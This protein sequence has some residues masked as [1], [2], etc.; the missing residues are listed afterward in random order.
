MWLDRLS[1]HSTQPSPSPSSTPV[2]ARSFSP[3]PNRRPYLTPGPQRP[4]LNP[5]SSSLSLL[6]PNS[7]SSSLPLA[8][9]APTASGLRVQI[10]SS[11][12]ADVQDPS[13]VLEDILRG[14]PKRALPDD[15]PEILVERPEEVVADIE[16]GDLSLQ[17]FAQGEVGYPKRPSHVHTRSTE[18]VEEYGKAKDKFE[19]LHRSVA[20]CDEVLKSVEMYLQ[21]FQSDLGAV[22]AEIQILQDRSS[23]LNT[24]LENRKIVEKILGPAVEDIS[25]SP[26]VV[27]KIAEGPVDEGFSKALQELE[28][29]SKAV[30]AKAKGGLNV[31]A[32]DDLK[33]LLEDLTNKAVERIRDYIVAQIKAL[34]SPSINA[35]IIQQQGFLKYKE[36]YAFLARHQKQLAEELCRAYINTMRWYYLHHFTRYHEA[37]QKMK[38]HAIDQHDAMGNEAGAKR[39][40]SKMP[41]MPHETFSI[42]R[43]LDLLKTSTHNALTLHV[44][45]E[46]KATHYLELPFHTFNLALIDNASFEYTFLTSYFAPAQSYQAINRTFAQIF[47]PTFALGQ[48]LTRSLIDASLDAL[49]ILLCVRLTQAFAFELQ[50]RKVPAVEAY[51]NATNM[52]LWPR[53]QQ[54]MDAHCKS[55]AA[56]TS[57]LPGRPAAGSSLLASSSSSSASA[58]AAADAQSTA[59]VA[60]TQRFANF[61]HGVLALSADAADDEPVSHSLVRLRAEYVAYL[62]KRAKGIGEARKRTRFLFNN[63]SLVGTIL[64]GTG[65]RMAEEMRGF[66]A[67]VRGRCE[68]GL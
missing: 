40:N 28:K 8:A 39:G 37:L 35:Q 33:P 3:A 56:L 12:P 38:L 65:G 50:R 43:R 47:E 11:P 45:E 9:R 58:A 46:D 61:L 14:P 53:F 44:L 4:G 25:I 67:E 59:P 51:T 48:S 60:L 15:Q 13:K 10:N 1:A 30:E 52:L 49:G 55:I 62:E 64:E 36:L 68:G 57:S 26:A 66:F 42:G 18:S 17:A 2:A 27:R 19:D 31:K 54:V 22:S 34:R 32:L 7:S 20:A 21:G 5:R 41:A 24:R 16:F 29:R 23:S 63:A 6:S